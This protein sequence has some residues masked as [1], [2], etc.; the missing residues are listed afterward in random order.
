M[1]F[2]DWPL[3]R[4]FR[5]GASVRVT[6]KC[7]AIRRMTAQRIGDVLNDIA[8]HWVERIEELDTVQ[9]Q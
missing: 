2:G 4:A 6:I 1:D 9:A 5:I 8:E 3:Q 7:S